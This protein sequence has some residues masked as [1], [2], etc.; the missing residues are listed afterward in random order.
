MFMGGLKRMSGHYYRFLWTSQECWQCQSNWRMFNS[1]IYI[2]VPPILVS[3]SV[4]VPILV[5]CGSIEDQYQNYRT[6]LSYHASPVCS[7]PSSNWWPGKWR[8]RFGIISM[9]RSLLQASKGRETATQATS[10]NTCRM[11]VWLSNK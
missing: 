2:R 7:F 6:E 4:S 1:C 3:V 9:W 5:Q 10:A 11:C 8:M